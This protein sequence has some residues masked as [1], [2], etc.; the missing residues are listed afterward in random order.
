M[1]RNMMRRFDAPSDRDASTNSFSRSESTWPRM[2]RATYGVFARTMMKMT[3]ERPGSI[4]PPMQ[5]FWPEQAVAEAEAEQQHRERQ[6]HVERAGDRRVDPAAVEGR[7]DA[8]G[9]AEDDGEPGADEA[10]SSDTCAP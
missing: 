4:R 2:I 6:H 1:S 10:T 5:P 7:D 8:E 3:T 9:H